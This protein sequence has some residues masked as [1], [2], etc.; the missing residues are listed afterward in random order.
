VADSSNYIIVYNAGAYGNFVGW[1]IE[2]LTNK[3]S[4]SNRPWDYNGNSHNNNLVYYNSVKEACDKKING[5]VHPI[6]ND[7]DDFLLIIDQLKKHY[8][9]IIFLYPDINDFAWNINNKFEK[10]FQ[11]GWVEEYFELMS[12]NYDK[13]NQSKNLEPW[14]K[15]EWLSYTM[16]SQHFHEVR[17]N[18]I[19]KIQDEKIIKISLTNLRDNFL[20]TM[21]LI[22]GFLELNIKR[23]KEDILDLKNEWLS[24]Q[25]HKNKDILINHAVYA[26]V[27]NIEFDFDKKLTLFDQ[28][29]IQRQLREKHN[30]KIKCFNLNNWPKNTTELKKLLYKEDFNETTL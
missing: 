20:E 6:K 8:N 14:E 23:T 19:S 22:C 24:L 17:Y 10:I 2:W 15:R 13:W 5:I 3:V 30:I 26:I 16:H 21:S 18:S 28:S 7:K 4:E 27:N 12:Q 11:H 25:T 9:K 1:C 29:E